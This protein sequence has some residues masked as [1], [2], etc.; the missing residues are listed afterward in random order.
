MAHKL[1]FTV[2]SATRQLIPVQAD[3]DGDGV[4]ETVQV[5]GLLIDLVSADGSM[6][7]ALKFRRDLDHVAEEFVPG[8]EIEMSIKVVTK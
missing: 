4:M 2:V 1:N 7:P 3:V 5:P 6:H 8:V